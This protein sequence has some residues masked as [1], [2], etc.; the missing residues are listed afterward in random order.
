MKAF[1]TYDFM[2][3]LNNCADNNTHSDENEN[4]GNNSPTSSQKSFK[5]TETL[6]FLSP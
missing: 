6:K 2:I 4:I 3:A 5:R 1:S